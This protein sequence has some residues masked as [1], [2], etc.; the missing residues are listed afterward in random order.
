MFT[1]SV[2][3]SD[4]SPEMWKI[5]IIL[6]CQSF[7][8]F[9][10]I[11]FQFAFRQSELHAFS[12]WIFSPLAVSSFAGK[13]CKKVFRGQYDKTFFTLATWVMTWSKIL[14]FKLI[15]LSTWVRCRDTKTGTCFYKIWH[16][17][18]FIWSK[19]KKGWSSIVPLIIS[20][21][22][23]QKCFT[24]HGSQKVRDKSVR[25]LLRWYGIFSKR[26]FS[27]VINFR[28]HNLKTPVHG[29]V[30]LWTYLGTYLPSYLPT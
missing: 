18:W 11:K 25:R 8:L 6:K 20:Q 19:F 7:N 10:N 30:D 15:T 1:S 5:K 3:S 4:E 23:G 28:F 27:E 26:T 12:Y 14:M 9:L 17:Y 21:V 13:I 16:S 22:V 24:F 29:V 2:T